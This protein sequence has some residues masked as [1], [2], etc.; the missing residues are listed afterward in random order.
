MLASPGLRSDRVSLLVAA[1]LVAAPATVRAQASAARL[2]VDAAPSCST[3]DELIA[4]VAAR[5]TR[6]RFV[7]DGA[8]LPVMSARI[9]AGPKG[10]VVAEL[11]VVEPDGRRFA[12][13]LEAPSCAAATDALALVVAITLDPGAVSAETAAPGDAAPPAVTAP[14][15]T[16]VAPE[17]AGARKGHLDGGDAGEAAPAASQRRLIVGAGGE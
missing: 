7:S 5:S 3:R 14:S 2:D 16:S 9:A 6:I 10:S 11:T 1:V 13:R 17:P 15:P 4:R 8:G 12:R